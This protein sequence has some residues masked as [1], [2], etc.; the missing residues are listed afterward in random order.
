MP[1][2]VRLREW[3]R[4]GSL[5]LLVILLAGSVGLAFGWA[6]LPGRS[7][8]LE[9]QG[10]DAVNHALMIH[11]RAHPVP[12]ELQ[13]TYA[14]YPQLMHALAGCFMPVLGDNAIRA[15]D[16]VSWLTLLGLFAVQWTLLC[17][18]LPA[19]P[20]LAVLTGWQ[21][22]RLQTHFADWDFFHVNC[23]PP[24][25]LGTLLVWLQVLLLATAAPR[26]RWLRD[27]A[28]LLLAL[29]AY[30]SH[31]VPG[32]V[33]FATLI[34]L[35][36]YHLLAGP[37]RT[38]ASLRLVLTG[39]TAAGTLLG[40][41]Q[42]AV[43]AGARI[44][45]GG[46]LLCDHLWL[47]LLWVPTLLLACVRVAW[48][49]WRHSGPEEMELVLSSALLAAGSIQGYLTLETVLHVSVGYYS[50]LKL[51]WLTFPL[52]SLLWLCWLSRLLCRTW[53]L[54]RQRVVRVAVAAGCLLLALYGLRSLVQQDPRRPSL[55]L[56]PPTDLVERTRLR[57]AR[58]AVAASHRLR[59]L[60]GRTNHAP[61]YVYFHD[62]AMPFGS[63][64]ATVT[65]LETNHDAAYGCWLSLHFKQSL[66]DLLRRERVG[67]IL[68]PRHADARAVVGVAVP[69]EPAG[70]FLRCDLQCLDKGG[71]TRRGGSKKGGRRSA[72]GSTRTLTPG[73]GPCGVQR[74]TRTVVSGPGLAGAG[75]A[76]WVC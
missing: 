32:A 22:L 69:V 40:S 36:G 76:R 28:A 60:L 8:D 62:P 49:R 45:A 71:L 64:F 65:A 31:I 9:H 52:A 25:A 57:Q 68:L 14:S 48:Q 30:N 54:P 55:R 10:I 27:G 18:L 70:P 63:L 74:K 67:L 39:V 47:L 51:F 3:C 19:L 13:G 11:R 15:M 37:G 75:P 44:I 33:A 12:R 61:P 58:D 17:R 20:A 34:I 4:P 23:Y 29:L 43:M 72:G 46:T 26:V 59:R 35:E 2:T 50:A 21:W 73:I 41:E 66:A 6:A 16:C 5:R 7:N 38:G 24:Q 53:R 1:L 56:K 42:L